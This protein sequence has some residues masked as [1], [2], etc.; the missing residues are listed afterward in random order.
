MTFCGVNIVA[1]SELLPTDLSYYVWSWESGEPNLSAGSCVALNEYGR[2]HMLD[3]QTPLHSLCFRA[4]HSDWVLSLSRHPW[5][6]KG[7]ADVVG[8]AVA[9]ALTG[10]EARIVTAVAA[11]QMVW[12]PMPPVP[13]PHQRWS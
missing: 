11:G 9:L 2:W 6:A 8:G 5:S 1:K 10:Y 4:K 7:C 12:L 3:C 13:L